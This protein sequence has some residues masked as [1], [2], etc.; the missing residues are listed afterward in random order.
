MQANQKSVGINGYENCLFPLPYILVNTYYPGSIH[1]WSAIDYLAQDNNVPVPLYAMVSCRCV[2]IYT[3]SAG[4][5]TQFYE[6]LAPV[7]CSDGT[8]NVIHFSSTHMN[9]FTGGVGSVFSQGDLMCY[10]GNSGIS[11]WNHSHFMLGKGPFTQMFCPAPNGDGYCLCGS[12][13]NQWD[14]MY[15]NNTQILANPQG[16]NWKTVTDVPPPPV[17]NINLS[18]ENVNFI[19]NNYIAKANGNAYINYIRIRKYFKPLNQNEELIYDGYTVPNIATFISNEI[20]EVRKTGRFRALLTA[21]DNYNQQAEIEQIINIEFKESENIMP[22]Y[23]M[24][25]IK[26]GFNPC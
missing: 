23:F 21:R 3:D 1:N 10:T 7:N 22:L 14:I 24:N 4:G 25:I 8:T 6:S 20:N 9:N 18:I 26:G 13:P 12:Q 5:K 15:V 17:L 19:K 11:S 2:A 16:W